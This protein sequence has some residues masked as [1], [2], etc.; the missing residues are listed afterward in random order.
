MAVGGKEFKYLCLSVLVV[1]A[2]SMTNFNSG[3]E[4]MAITLYDRIYSV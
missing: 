2:T 1:T 4:G 3:E